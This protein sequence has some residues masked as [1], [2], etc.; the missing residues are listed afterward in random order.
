MNYTSWRDIY[1]SIFVCLDFP[2]DWNGLRF[3]HEWN[4]KNAGG[5]PAP[6]TDDNKRIWA[7]NPQ[8]LFAPRKNVELF[9]SLA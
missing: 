7:K 5:T 9:V 4:V 6:M 1:N 3:E 8:F 2:E